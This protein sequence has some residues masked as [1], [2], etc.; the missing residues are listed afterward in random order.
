[1]SKK[2]PRLWYIYPA[3][4]CYISLGVGFAYYSQQAVQSLNKIYK[5]SSHV[6]FLFIRFHLGIMEE[7]L[8]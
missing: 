1:M 8:K 2:R 7:Q 4:D 3:W 6:L 5:Q